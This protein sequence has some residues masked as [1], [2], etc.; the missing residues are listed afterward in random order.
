MT[1]TA[2]TFGAISLGIGMGLL[3][4]NMVAALAV[5]CLASILVLRSE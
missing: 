1:I 4:F 5:F 2:Q 3:P